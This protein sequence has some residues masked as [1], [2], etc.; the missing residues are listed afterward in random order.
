MHALMSC[1]SRYSHTAGPPKPSRARSPFATG[2]IEARIP[3]ICA[4]RV[5]YG[6]RRVHALLKREGWDVNVKPTHRIYRELGPQ[7]SEQDAE[8]ARECEAPGRP[9]GGS[10]PE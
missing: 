1:Q 8:A 4:T 6:Y 9:P 3:D 10:G 5:R 7:R 2:I